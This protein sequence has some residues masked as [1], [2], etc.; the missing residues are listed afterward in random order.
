MGLHSRALAAAVL[1]P[2]PRTPQ[3]ENKTQ[4]IRQCWSSPWEHPASKK[5]GFA[6]GWLHPP[7]RP[8]TTASPALWG[9]LLLLPHVLLASAQCLLWLR[10]PERAQGAGHLLLHQRVL[11]RDGVQQDGGQP[12]SNRAGCT[13]SGLAPT[14]PCPPAAP[15]SD[16]E[17]RQHLPHGLATLHACLSCADLSYC[18]PRTPTSLGCVWQFPT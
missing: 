13:C 2:L 9:Y 11:V 5:P 6:G 14:P 3:K 4:A 1:T 16:P 17:L 10:L 18:C 12:C 8:P 15:D 7:A